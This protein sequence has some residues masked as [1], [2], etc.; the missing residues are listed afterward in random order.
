MSSSV[1]LM[2]FPTE[3]KNDPVMFQSPPTR[4]ISYHYCFLWWSLL[5]MDS[6][7]YKNSSFSWVGQSA[8]PSTL[9][10]IHF[11]NP[12]TP[13]TWD[14]GHSNAFFHVRGCVD[15]SG[16]KKLSIPRFRVKYPLNILVIF[17]TADFEISGFSSSSFWIIMHQ[18][19][20]TCPKMDLDLIW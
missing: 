9:L 14:G 4:V 13:T 17:D 6:I 5:I 8:N 18:R 7:W 3:W 20:L 19:F 10:L 1:G 11:P 2:T 16:T 15:C 12:L